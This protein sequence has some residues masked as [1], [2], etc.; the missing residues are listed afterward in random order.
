VGEKEINSNKIT[1]K[2]L[3]SKIEKTVDLTSEDIL[4]VLNS[5][6]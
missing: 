6:E 1:I 4:A 5:N 2:N 3:S